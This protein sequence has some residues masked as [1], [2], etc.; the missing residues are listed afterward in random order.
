[1]RLDHLLSK[2]SCQPFVHVC[3]ARGAGQLVDTRWI[4]TIGQLLLAVAGPVIV[5]F[6]LKVLLSSWLGCRL[7]VWSGAFAFRLLL[8][9]CIA[10]TSIF[11]CIPFGGVRI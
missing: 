7:V 9:N 10:S 2:E 3:W 6:A 4:I 5:S 11:M 1:M 8:E